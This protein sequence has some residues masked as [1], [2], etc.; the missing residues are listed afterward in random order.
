VVGQFE[1]TKYAFSSSL[2]DLMKCYLFFERTINEMRSVY[3][4]IV[5]DTNPAASSMAISAMNVADLILSPINADRFAIRGLRFLRQILTRFG[6]ENQ[7]IKRAVIVNAIDE[8]DRKMTNF[9][10]QASHRLRKK[11]VGWRPIPLRIGL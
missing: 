6:P 1:L 5:L 2:E 4:L 10:T 11:R 7:E 8:N 3:D 9:V